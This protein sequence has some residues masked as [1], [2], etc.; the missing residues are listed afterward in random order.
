MTDHH[1]YNDT[2]NI[3]SL[4]KF[5]FMLPGANDF[6]F[7]ESV[8][9]SIR[10][11]LFLTVSKQGKYL[12]WL[13]PNAFYEGDSDGSQ[14]SPPS[15]ESVKD[16]IDKEYEWKLSTYY[17]TSLHKRDPKFNTHNHH[18][19]HSSLPC[20]RIFRKGEPIYRCLT[21]GYDESCALCSHCYQP[22]YH[23]GHKVHITI[24]LQKN[25]GVCDCGDP[26]A[27]VND[28]YCPY[29]S[30]S[31]NNK[32]IAL[33]NS[34]MPPEFEYSF[35]STI[36]T[37][38]DYVID[39]MSH[40]DLQFIPPQDL[41]PEDI[42][43][44]TK[45][46]NLD[47]TKYGFPSDTTL[48]DTNNDEYYLMVYNDQFRHYRD[49]VQRIRLASRKVQE[50]AIMVADKAQS[51]GKAR[52][53]SSK[54]IELLR[55]RQAVLSSTGLATCIR[56][57]RDVFREDMCD[58]ILLWINT[59]TES[60]L[61]K[62]SNSAKNL[63][64]RAFCKR[65]NNGLAFDPEIHSLLVYNSGRLDFFNQIPKVPSG[66]NDTD[67][68]KASEH[69]NFTP[70]KWNIDPDLCQ[71]CDYNLD[72]LD[73]DPQK[74]HLGSR[75][76]YL[77]YLDI[78]FWKSIRSLLHDMYSTSL[79]T[80]L[81]FKNIISCQ[82]VDIYPAVA[83]MFLT[84]DR[85]PELNIMGTL[86]TQLFTTPSNSTSIVEHGDLSR[87]LA[88]IY[89]FLTVEEIKSPQ[90][91]DVTHKVS[92]KSLKNR[93]WGQIF[94]DSGYILS[95][96]RSSKMILSCDVIAMACDILALFQGRPVLKRESQN[97]VEYESS[98]YT[99]FFHAILVI[100][101]FGEFIAHCLDNFK[102]DQFDEEIRTLSNNA[103][104]YV[105]RFLLSLENNDYPG[106]S[107]EMV[108]INLV[109]HA[110]EVEPFSGIK[111]QS[112]RMDNDKVS[113]LHPI[114]SFLSWLIELSN[115]SSIDEVKSVID[116]STSDYVI[117]QSL[118]AAV[119]PTVLFD[120]S[121]RTVVLMSQ[122][123][124][125]F[126][127][128]NGFSVRSQLQLYKNTILRECGYMRDIF[129]VQVFAN[130]CPPDLVCFT[131]F[132]RWLL[133]EGWV[134]PDKK[135]TESH[136][137]HD[138]EN[139]LAYHQP[140]VDSKS[141]SI[142]PKSDM[143]SEGDH[144]ATDSAVS[145]D[146][147][148]LPYIVEEC[149]NFMIHILTHDL[150]LR[151]L[152]KET[153]T[154]TRIENEIIQNLCFGAMSYTKLCSQIPDH[155]TAEKR[156]DIILSE[157]TVFT[158]PNSTKDVGSYRL[159]DEWF[160]CIN[161][162]YFNYSAN[163][164]DD[165]VK[166][167]KDKIC[168]KTSLKDY[169]AVITPFMRNPDEL[170]IYKYIG[171]FSVSVYFSDFLV[172]TMLYINE[173]GIE[174]V[175]S[176]LETLL[177][178]IHI[179]SYENTVN[180]DQYG[181]FF[182]NFTRVSENHGY[183]VAAIL[184]KLLQ[185]ESFKLYH[186]KIRAI[187]V[188]FGGKHDIRSIIV[189]QTGEF[190]IKLL[191]EPEAR[192]HTESDLDRKKRIAKEKQAKLMA[193]F[194][195][196]QSLFLKNHHITNTEDSQVEMEEAD[197]STGWSFPEAHCLLCQNTSED[198]GP[199]GII[200]YVSKSSE[201]RSVPFDDKYWFLRAFSD[202]SNLDEDETEE[203]DNLFTDN[204]RNYMRK[205]SEDN[206]IGPGFDSQNH[207]DSKLVSLSCGHGMHFQ[208]YLNFVNNNRNRQNQI[209]RNSPENIEHKEFLC[210]LCKALN[211]MF[212]PILW[213][214]NKRS[215]KKFLQPPADDS[216]E[217]NILG[218]VLDNLQMFSTNREK[219]FPEF[220]NNTNKEIQD[221]SCLTPNAQ[222]MIGQT[223]SSST[224]SDQQYFR[225]LLS[226]MFQVM[227]L[228][229]F[230]N[231]FKADSVTVL[232]NTI[233]STE[234][235][236]RGESSNNSLVIDQLSNNSLINLRSLNEFRNT[237]LLMKT[238]N[239]T[240][241]PDQKF[242][243]YVKIISNLLTLYSDKLSNQRLLEQDFF[244][245]LVNIFPVVT[246]GFLF[247]VILRATFMAHL[248]QNIFLISSKILANLF[249]QCAEYSILD[250]PV[251]STV[252]YEKAQ[253]AV[254]LFKRVKGYL[255]PHGD[256]DMILND[257]K[258]GYVFYSMLIK[259]CTPFLRRAAIYAFVVCADFDDLDPM[260]FN[261]IFLEADRLCSF[262]S[263]DS[264]GDLISRMSR[265]DDMTFENQRFTS[266][267]EYF[268]DYGNIHD[269]ESR[270]QL[271]YPGLIKLID[272]PERLDF[273]FTKYYYLDKYDNPH[274]SIE[275]P[276]VCLFCGEV[277]NI[278]RCA[279]GASQGQCTTHLL[280]EC[281]NNIGIFLLPMDKSI[282]LLYK[283][284]GS[285]IEAP[286]LNQHGELPGESKQSKTLYLMKSRYN[287][288]IKQIWLEH[289]IP[290]Y[291]ARKLDS[292]IDAG[293][294]DTL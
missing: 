162:Y 234:I 8:R 68:G 139:L 226:N 103:V 3:E 123:K 203:T 255:D 65:W 246:S 9:T 5:L 283:N 199:F 84:M 214:N 97:H 153:V 195:K 39:I 167:V 170:G 128:R 276:A 26:E 134:V 236:L 144:E 93:R 224:T 43:Y 238:K 218:G 154:K 156:F 176:L 136:L 14:A 200:S 57:H 288:F 196:Q 228:F 254:D 181:S 12:D 289:N 285:F 280:K 125:G 248:I 13:F 166:L 281:P 127:V 133:L 159:K 130:S 118:H 261:D 169:Q 220:I 160:D 60:E 106:L 231:I 83:D 267:F 90:N 245:I 46:S 124:S 89:G 94:F 210:P 178:L 242:D 113:F 225:M 274:L 58:E 249:Y 179:C 250:V 223:S 146:S 265:E 122:I 52:V 158:P 173:L 155:I 163:T 64:C 279:I 34:V 29:A 294:W 293:G 239:W 161:P 273:F 6:T 32:T 209:T 111:V 188:V 100:Y 252:D 116:Q 237:T 114:H 75:L 151:G 147:K 150:H 63:F 275:E 168:S 4:K 71:L 44:Y 72:E 96:S 79:I 104:G 247:N 88:S 256:E 101:Q 82:Y 258:F 171:N 92:M 2:E 51:Y 217:N 108:D 221:F 212:V 55:E 22:E 73:Y 286:F 290:N 98:D 211:N 20:V 198:V 270:A 204:W 27:W 110:Y 208:C 76:Q 109:Q 120:Y 227:S 37:V 62:S 141:K 61:F 157:L 197:E 119:S 201:F 271:D 74:N 244:D 194:K 36:E 15:A 175:D 205:V 131:L 216:N 31:N 186:S 277:V 235:S 42:L 143:E 213:T 126:W 48:S 95:R 148:V 233:K 138:I 268:R 207:V 185:T 251:I 40:S 17:K 30:S 115:F 206:V 85:E 215:L 105:A 174:K 70:K 38:L 11:Q 177:H 189:A 202:P 182:Q 149:L 232:V 7:N 145:Y 241:N 47:P 87:I 59:L 183:S 66:K 191:E 77:I 278:Q 172:R 184:Y 102:N 78:R 135:K 25:G 291:I 253:I 1:S 132:N 33:A 121:I 152:P 137:S 24:C 69:W 10:K 229:N 140:G 269:Q 266:F 53:I 222:K 240:Q 56:S 264:L 263:I 28:F 67:R 292:V 259:A 187:F 287:K 49:A 193:K 190:D 41:S 272:L 243:V 54:K 129:M 91:L 257:A 23:V 45:N 117:S 35:L 112:F 16:R 86:S 18:A 180:V 142:S 262:M 21:C 230:P 81:T 284:G 219:W 282:L 80:N 107:D 50:F 192:E 260:K 19:F 165:A 99:A 164:K